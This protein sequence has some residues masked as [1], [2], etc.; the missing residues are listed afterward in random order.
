[1]SETITPPPDLSGLKALLL[2]SAA[3]VS[4]GGNRPLKQFVD[5]E[6]G[7]IE[8][9]CREPLCYR[10]AAEKR[11]GLCRDC[12]DDPAIRARYPSEH[13]AEPDTEA[14][15]AMPK[16]TTAKPGSPRKCRVLARRARQ[17]QQLWNPRDALI[18]LRD[19]AARAD[20]EVDDA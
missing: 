17:H 15:G 3:R 1:M 7:L 18:D 10:Q 19:E 2:T 14:V 16:A 20:A 9:I 13:L 5:P 12:Y 6:T 4:G 8:I 11:R